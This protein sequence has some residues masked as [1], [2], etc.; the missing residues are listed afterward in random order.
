MAAG[1]GKNW[2]VTTAAAAA[3]ESSSASSGIS[4]GAAADE[5]DAPESSADGDGGGAAGE[6]L[7][8]HMAT[9]LLG[10][11][12]PPLVLSFGTTLVCVCVCVCVVVVQCPPS[13][14]LLGSISFLPRTPTRV[15]KEG[16]SEREKRRGIPGEN[17][18]RRRE[19]RGLEE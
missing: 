8:S 12:V 17:S 2:R 11:G 16:R 5:E 3:V 10:A 14:S 6:S 9:R 18:R 15:M 19:Q 13:L 1:A 4:T 7:R